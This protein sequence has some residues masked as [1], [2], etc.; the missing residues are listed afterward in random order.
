M[1]TTIRSSVGVPLRITCSLVSSRFPTTEKVFIDVCV[2]VSKQCIL[3]HKTDLRSTE[4]GKNLLNSV[5]LSKIIMMSSL[6]SEN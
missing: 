6:G 5:Y 3:K 4:S 2:D 1:I